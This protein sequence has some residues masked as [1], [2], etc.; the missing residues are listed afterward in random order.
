VGAIG[1]SRMGLE[2]PSPLLQEGSFLGHVYGAD[3]DTPGCQSE[4]FTPPPKDLADEYPISSDLSPHGLSGPVGSSFS[5]YQYPII[6][7]RLSFCL[8]TSPKAPQ[9]DI[10]DH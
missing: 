3:T 1:Q 5:N 9:G 8:V 4:T 10:A 2:R 7:K 6:S